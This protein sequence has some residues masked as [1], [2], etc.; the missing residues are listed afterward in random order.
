M[1]IDPAAAGYGVSPYNPPASAPAATGLGKDDFLNLLV[2][3]LRYQDPSEPL[4]TS[5]L[6]AQTTQLSTMEQLTELTRLSQDAFHLQMRTSA[7]SLV[8]KEVTYVNGEGVRAT[9]V[10]DSV[11][12]ATTPP[13]AVI[14]SV[15]VPM[16]QIATVG[17]ADRPTAPDTGR[18][19]GDSTTT[20]PAAADTPTPA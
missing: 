7:T 1:T 17:Q 3:S 20:P 10:V 15:V 18:G 8:G 16:N 19:S 5:E 12:F 13:G 11:D 9:G 4:S 14:G 6:M 2:T